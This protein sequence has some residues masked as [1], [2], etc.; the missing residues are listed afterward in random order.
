MTCPRS[1]WPPLAKGWPAVEWHGVR[2]TVIKDR[3]SD[4]GNG[5]IGPGTL[6]QEGPR[7]AGR[8]GSESGDNGKHRWN[9]ERKLKTAIMSGKQDDTQQDLRGK[10]SG[11]R[12]WSEQSGFLSGFEKRVTGYCGGVGPL[13][14]ERRDNWQQ[15]KNYVC[16]SINYT[17]NF[18][19]SNWK[20]MTVIHL[21]Q[22]APY[23]GATRN[24][25]P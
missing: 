6:L 25:R 14:N 15:I 12:S 7:K 5:K 13:R 11:W 17:R 19:S 10:P 21:D 18:C 8:S 22:L 20:E 16:G 24:E 1:S 3:R 9:K 4:R 2:D 23:Q